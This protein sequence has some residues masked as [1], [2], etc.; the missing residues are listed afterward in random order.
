MLRLTY[1][2]TARTKATD[3]Q[4]GALLQTS[5]LNNQAADIT[6]FLMA[7]GRRY[8]QVLEGPSNAVEDTFSRIVRDP[9]HFATV[10]LWREDVDS[11]LFPK[12]SMGCQS[13]GQSGVINP[14]ISF[15][16]DRIV[17]PTIKAQFEQFA[18]RSAA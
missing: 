6:G 18:M 2:S 10:V 7:G 9:R 11:R 13:A 8:L 1:I 4:L 16:I 5:R 12:W 3:A 17:N 14:G 15:L